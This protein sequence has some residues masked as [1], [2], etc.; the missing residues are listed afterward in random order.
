MLWLGVCCHGCSASQTRQRRN[1]K[2]DQSK[3]GPV[4][5]ELHQQECTD[6]KAP[7][8]NS[9]DSVFEPHM[10]HHSSPSQGLPAR[11]WL[12]LFWPLHGAAWAAVQRAEGSFSMCWQVMASSACSRCPTP[13]H[14]TPALSMAGACD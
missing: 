13:S 1:S 3:Q 10:H 6:S 14:G 2:Q 4:L 12:L 5:R 11:W 9:R 7:Q 8:K